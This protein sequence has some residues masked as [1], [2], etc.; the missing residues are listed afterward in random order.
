[1]KVIDHSGWKGF[2]EDGFSLRAQFE[3]VTLCVF[4][5]ALMLL[6]SSRQ[7]WQ[8][9]HYSNP[10]T[11]LPLLHLL[12]WLVGFVER[13]RLL[14]V[15]ENDSSQEVACLLQQ[16]IIRMLWGSYFVLIALE[17]ALY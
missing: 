1:M 14:R 5:S 9:G 6:V 13:K 12:P 11:L 17:Y 16:T 10:R 15:S 3:I 2:F 7:Y 4:L 8:P